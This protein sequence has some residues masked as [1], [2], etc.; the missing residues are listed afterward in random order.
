M[1]APLGLKFT[2][3]ARG[4]LPYA[5]ALVIL[6]Q[7]LNII[8]IPIWGALLLPG[9][10][11][12]NPL[13]IVATLFIDV[14][15]PL[16]IGLAMRAFASKQAGEWFPELAKVSNWAL[17]L[18]V[19]LTIV[20]NLSL[21]LSLIGSFALLISIIICLL[22]GILGYI[23]G[24]AGERKKRTGA[25]ITASRAT[26]PALLIAN[27]AFASQPKVLTGGIALA[28]IVTVLPL[29]V[30]IQWNKQDTTAGGV[31][32]DRARS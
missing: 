13:Q 20:G 2:Q 6:L 25:I 19:V 28:V 1:G 17:I 9:G 4:D 8:A 21:L 22:A 3:S 31:S 15:L 23:F 11:T 12:I 10:V 14:I 26:G 16:G 24:G 18:V 32:S 27:Q 29:L 7:I 5:I 30:M